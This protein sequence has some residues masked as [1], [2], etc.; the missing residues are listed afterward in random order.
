MKLI[1]AIERHS[2]GTRQPNF[3]LLF[4]Y[5]FEVHIIIER[6]RLLSAHIVRHGLKQPLGVRLI[7]STSRCTRGCCHPYHGN[8]SYPFVY[9]SYDAS[10]SMLHAFLRYLARRDRRMRHLIAPF[11]LLRTVEPQQRAWCG[12]G[13]SKAPPPNAMCA[14][15]VALL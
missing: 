11:L 12:G 8:N 4:A 7:G 3:L 10:N 1:R 5:E 2:A 9:G 15:V 14:R 6:Y 13:G